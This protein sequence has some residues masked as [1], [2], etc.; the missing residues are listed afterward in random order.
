MNLLKKYLSIIRFLCA[1]FIFALG[2]SITAKDFA[3]PVSFIDF[4]VASIAGVIA[5]L[6]WY[7]A[8]LFL[9]VISR[10]LPSSIGL[11]VSVFVNS[12][13]W[14]IVNLPYLLIAFGSGYVLRG[15]IETK[16]DFLRGFACVIVGVTFETSRRLYLY[17]LGKLRFKLQG[18]GTDAVSG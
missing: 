4:V 8:W 5:S 7:G 11:K 15:L 12:K 18:D 1:L 9:D 17:A 10:R 16:K 6:L 13:S 3:L 14:L 2:C